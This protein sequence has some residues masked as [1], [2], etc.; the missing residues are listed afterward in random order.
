MVELR[1]FDYQLVYTINPR[2]LVGLR[3]LRK[4]AISTG[5]RSLTLRVEAN[6]VVLDSESQATCVRL[7]RAR[8]DDTRADGRKT[9]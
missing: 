9:V 5:S 1:R 4:H 7:C 8:N 3:A 2:F 6:R